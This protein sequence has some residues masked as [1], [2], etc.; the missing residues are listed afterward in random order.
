[1][2]YEPENRY[3]IRRVIITGSKKP[4]IYKPTF[5]EK[6]DDFWD[7]VEEI[8]G[9][10]VFVVILVGALFSCADESAANATPIPAATEIVAYQ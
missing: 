9:W 10:I 5:K 4:T 1:M 8:G 7:R 6:W 2:S 3:V